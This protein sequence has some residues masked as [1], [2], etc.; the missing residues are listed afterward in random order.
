VADLATRQV[1]T[2]ALGGAGGSTRA[3]ELRLPEGWHLQRLVADGLEVSPQHVPLTAR[4]LEVYACHDDGLCS[5][6]EVEVAD[7]VEVRF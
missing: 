6:A 7:R 4:Q 1:T 5:R 2:L 3:V